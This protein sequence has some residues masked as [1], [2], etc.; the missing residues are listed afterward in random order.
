M[1]M[2]YLCNCVSSLLFLPSALHNSAPTGL[3]PNKQYTVYPSRCTPLFSMFPNDYF[4]YLQSLV[5]LIIA[6]FFYFLLCGFCRYLAAFDNFYI[7]IG[8]L[9]LQLFFSFTEN[10]VFM[11]LKTMLNVN[12]SQ[13]LKIFTSYDSYPTSAL[14]YLTITHYAISK[15]P[16]YCIPWVEYSLQPDSYILTKM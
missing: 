7:C 2:P 16:T 5:F 10:G 9:R 15:E 6:M 8:M 4:L 3:G 12:A 14:I 1:K 11:I 13:N